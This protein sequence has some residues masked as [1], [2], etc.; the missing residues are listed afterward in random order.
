MNSGSHLP[1]ISLLNGEGSYSGRLVKLGQTQIG[2]D[3]YDVSF[4]DCVQVR[5][6]PTKDG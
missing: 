3:L 5:R 2:V 1:F 4:H 6:V